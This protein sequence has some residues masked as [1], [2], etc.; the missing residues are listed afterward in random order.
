MLKNLWHI[1][2]SGT[3]APRKSR[4]LGLTGPLSCPA[5]QD[6]KCVQQ[7]VEKVIKVEAK[8]VSFQD[9]SKQMLFS[10]A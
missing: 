3:E 7:A 5:G 9:L 6:G 1:C 2:G 8:T 10:R 4:L